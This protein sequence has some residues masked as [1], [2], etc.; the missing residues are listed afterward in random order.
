L[1][2]VGRWLERTK[3][4]ELPQLWD[5][6]RGEMSLIGPRP[7]VP[8]FVDLSDPLWRKVLVV[9]PG[10]FGA[11]QLLARNEAE[12]YPDGC[13]DIEA[14]YREHILP[15]KLRVD[16]AYVERARLLNDLRL[17]FGGVMVAAF[18]TI[19]GS[20]VRGHALHVTIL[21]FDITASVFTLTFGFYLHYQGLSNPFKVPGVPALLALSVLCRTACFLSLGIYRRRLSVLTYSDMMRTVR[22]VLYG[23]GL[24]LLLSPLLSLPLPR[25]VLLF[26][27]LLLAVVLL[28]KAYG[29]HEILYAHREAAE[30]LASPAVVL[31]VLAATLVNVA[32]FLTM[33]RWWELTEVTKATAAQL[34]GV[35]AG[36]ALVRTYGFLRGLAQP[37]TGGWDSLRQIPRVLRGVVA[38]SLFVYMGVNLIYSQVLTVPVLLGDLVVST[39]IALLLARILS[40]CLRR[41]GAVRFGA[42]DAP[43]RVLVVGIA[44]ETEFYLCY[45]D[46]LPPPRP[47]LLGIVDAGSSGVRAQRINNVPVIGRISHLRALLEA[48]RIDSVVYFPEALTAIQQQEVVD[49][50]HR[51]GFPARAFPELEA[52]THPARSTQGA[53]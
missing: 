51:Y 27:A 2:Q 24:L 38:G 42:S 49:A 22:S 30:K 3:F 4:D 10:I 35:L 13:E 21:L 33:L 1:T 12:L 18:G 36:F 15:G 53:S 34:L 46:S 17:L 32:T 25:S 20:A 44:P 43:A 6:L 9:R 52:L 29:I 50:C 31:G 23:S 19:T 14:F 8:K 26:D 5:V 47:E 28:G 45:L 37:V 40:P 41:L 16:A 39:A 7:E 48:H 11:N